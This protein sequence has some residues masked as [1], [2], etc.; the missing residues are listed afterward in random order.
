MNFLNA[1]LNKLREPE[2]GKGIKE[3]LTA[4]LAIITIITTAIAAIQRE[5][6]KVVEVVKT[7]EVVKSEECPPS[8]TPQLQLTAGWINDPNE[9]EFVRAT[10]RIPNFGDTPAGKASLSGDG[11]VFLWEFAKAVTGDVLPDRNQ[12]GVGSC[13]SFGTACAVEH[14]LLAQIVQARMNGGQAKD[15][16]A[17]C[18]EVIYG[19]SRVEIGGGRI[20]GD[21]SV[22]AWAAQFIAQY[23]VIPREKIE[24]YDLTTYSE[25][26]CRK[27][28]REGV[29]AKL[30]T[31]AKQ[32][33]VKG[34]ALVR[35]A[36]EAE[37]AI[38]QGY[39][40]AVCSNQG[41]A[42]ARD[43]QGFAAPQGTWYHCMAIIGVKKGSR[44]GFFIQNSW[45]SDWISGPRFPTDA[46]AGGF[47][48]DWGTVERML[49][50]GD[51]WAFSDAVGFPSRELDFFIKAEPR[52]KQQL[53]LFDA[54][55]A[56]AP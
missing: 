15:F 11:D 31:V 1:I 32:S 7:V 6:P 17:L 2:P 29:P 43:S 54:E 45:G 47:W 25:S 55:F 36:A 48:A 18:Q 52:R 9:V 14:L 33:P 20:S 13:V 51:S 53:K 4:I 41:F 50:Q 22:G 26:L 24:G 12:G 38:R 46:P 39:A 10:N 21:G 30:E 8:N 34:T 5:W 40:I 3:R 16:K 19:G 49:K 44:P 28:G 42:S 37:K 23:G 56:L 35:T 27:W